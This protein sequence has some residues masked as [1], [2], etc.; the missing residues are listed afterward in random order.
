VLSAVG[1][2]NMQF[3]DIP[4]FTFDKYR[5]FET[6]VRGRS[7]SLRMTPVDRS[8]MNFLLIFN[9]NY[10]YILYR[11]WH[12]WFQEILWPWN[13]GQGSLKVIET[14]TIW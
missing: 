2:Y 6:E 3:S 4:R 12:I 5:D 1:Q 13:L 14:G 8:H 9:S 10:G 7:T 11:F